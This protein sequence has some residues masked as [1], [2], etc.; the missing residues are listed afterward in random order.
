MIAIQPPAS[1]S[2]W[3]RRL[4]PAAPGESS[5]RHWRVGLL[6]PNSL[7]GTSAETSNGVSM[8]L[9]PRS[10]ICRRR[11]PTRRGGGSIR[12]NSVTVDAHFGDVST[13]VSGPKTDRALSEPD[14]SLTRVVIS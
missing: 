10:P 1:T 14:S 7:R 6:S 11:E 4:V 12:R 13:S 5:N 9:P 3:A 8:S 2:K